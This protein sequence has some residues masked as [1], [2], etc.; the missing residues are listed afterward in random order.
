M[1][2]NNFI[3]NI[4]NYLSENIIS[5]NI[6]FG[7]DNK[8]NTNNPK[9]NNNVNNKSNK[10]LEKVIHNVTP[11]EHNSHFLYLNKSNNNNNKI[12]KTITER[13]NKTELTSSVPIGY[14]KM[15]L[16]NIDITMLFVKHNIIIKYIKVND[17]NYIKSFLINKESAEYN[18]YNNN[19]N[20]CVYFKERNDAM[21]EICA[22]NIIGE[23][24]FI[25]II[26]GR[27]INY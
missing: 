1:S 23:K 21:L 7:S 17:I 12:H 5:G 18:C 26:N 3:N 11:D 22:E 13:E 2:N 4:M 15:H 8:A 14:V 10:L 16:E 19:E 25:H 9:N 6:W 27:I 24:D 20:V